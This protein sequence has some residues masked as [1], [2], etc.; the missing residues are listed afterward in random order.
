MLNRPRLLLADDHKLVLDGFQRILAPEF[1]IVG[2][3]EDGRASVGRSSSGCT[4]M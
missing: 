2:T 4:P 3:A 1:E